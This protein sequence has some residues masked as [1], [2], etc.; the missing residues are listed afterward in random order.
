MPRAR[1]GDAGQ[2]F[3]GYKPGHTSFFV[4][5]WPGACGIAVQF[6]RIFDAME[7]TS[8]GTVACPHCRAQN[9][10]G[11]AFCTSCGRALPA[12]VPS[13]PRVIGGLDGPQSAVVAGLMQE[14]FVQQMSKACWALLVVAIIESFVDPIMLSN[15][16][17]DF[18]RH[19]MYIVQQSMWCAVIFGVALSFWILFV[20]AMKSPL[21]AAI[22]GLVLYVTIHVVVAIN[23]PKTLMQGWL[24]KVVIVSLLGQAIAAGIQSRSLP[25]GSASERG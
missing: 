13:G 21:P 12:G 24:L 10:A 6:C 11:L 4:A 19:G 9:A 25:H 2:F 15:T 7:S 5:E 14:H 20:W 18:A 3:E 1:D 22:V 8:T 16:A 17:E 23:N